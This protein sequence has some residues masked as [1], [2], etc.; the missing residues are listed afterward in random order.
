MITEMPKTM[1]NAW[2]CYA[3]VW[4]TRVG[5][6]PESGL[7]IQTALV[8]EAKLLPWMVPATLP[9]IVSMRTSLVD[10]AVTAPTENTGFAS[11]SSEATHATGKN[12][13]TRRA[14]RRIVDIISH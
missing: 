13:A 7:P 9:L 1:A 4:N 2:P 14:W 11:T 3:A 12:L 5:S 8:M 6:E 10:A